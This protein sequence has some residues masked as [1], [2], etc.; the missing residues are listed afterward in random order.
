MPGGASWVSR[1]RGGVPGGR[2]LGVWAAWCRAGAGLGSRGVGPARV[3][4]A[5]CRVGAGLGSRGVA[6]SGFGVA[7]CRSPGGEAAMGDPKQ[8]GDPVTLVSSNTLLTPKGGGSP[9]GR[10]QGDDTEA[11]GDARGVVS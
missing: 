9:R 8:V 6:C 3:W 10:S 2:V 7:W 4:V 1:P 11:E 5:W